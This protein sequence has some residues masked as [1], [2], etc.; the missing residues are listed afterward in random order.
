MTGWLCSDDVEAESA[1]IMRLH[2]LHSDQPRPR[3]I[4][5]GSQLSTKVQSI[6]AKKNT[7]LEQLS[8]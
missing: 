1:I 8:R 5:L 3:L 4:V 2:L 6:S 7:T